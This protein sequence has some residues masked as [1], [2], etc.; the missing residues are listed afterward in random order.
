MDL[1]LNDLQMLICHKTQ[2]TSY[3]T[4]R[5]LL[6][7][8]SENVEF[9][10]IRNCFFNANMKDLFENANID[11]ILSS[12]T[13]LDWTPVSQAIGEHSTHLDSSLICWQEITPDRLRPIKIHQLI[14][15]FNV[16]G[17]LQIFCISIIP[18]WGM[19]FYRA[20]VF[21]F[22]FCCNTPREFEIPSHTHWPKA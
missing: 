12:T 19:S 1:A 2:P 22:F 11:D 8:F 13:T 9:S 5:T 18:T 3:I 4:C 7:N 17:K 14:K 21:N 10:L 16:G 6:N 20:V 15:T